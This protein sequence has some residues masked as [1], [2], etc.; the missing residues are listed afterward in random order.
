M[1]DPG[2]VSYTFMPFMGYFEFLPVDGNEEDASQL[3][4][5][6]RLEMGHEYEVV[7]T[8]YSGLNQ[9]TSRVC[10]ESIPGH[11]VIYWELLMNKQEM[12]MEAV[13]GDVL[14]RSGT[15]EELM[16]YAVSRGTSMSQYKVPRCVTENPRIIELLDSR[17]V[18]SHFSPMAPHWAPDLQSSDSN[19][20]VRVSQD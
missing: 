12:E 15:F 19:G 17:V 2:E 8:T 3:V 5:L 1:C 9:H 7:V 4:D 13:N 16:D 11:Y 10:T 20:G 14:D 18:S 6:A